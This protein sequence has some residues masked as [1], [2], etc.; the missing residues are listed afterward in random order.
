MNEHNDRKAFQ[1]VNI[2]PKCYKYALHISVELLFHP[3]LFSSVLIPICMRPEKAKKNRVER[4]N[5]NHKNLVKNYHYT[6]KLLLLLLVAR[7]LFFCCFASSPSGKSISVKF[8]AEAKR[9]QMFNS[10]LAKM[11][12]YR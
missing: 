11:V 8:H 2:R 12:S 6:I 9:T 5:Q 3:D 7:I 10:L 1:C 4:Q